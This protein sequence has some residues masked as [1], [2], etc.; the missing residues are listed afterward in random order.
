VVLLTS[1][2]EVELQPRSLM[3]MYPALCGCISS[4]D[5]DVR[6]LVQRLLLSGR[7]AEFC[8]ELMDAWERQS[9]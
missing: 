5:L 2:L 8:L 1:A 4:S 3:E 6:Q 9:H 7:M